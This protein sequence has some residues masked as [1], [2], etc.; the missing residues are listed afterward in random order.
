[1]RI[2]AVLDCRADERADSNR[3]GEMAVEIEAAGYDS[4]WVMD[5]VVMPRELRTSYPAT[6]D[7]SLPPGFLDR[8]WYEAVVSLCIA[9]MA[10][11]RVELGTAVLVLPQREPLLFA[12]QIASV[13]ATLRRRMS[14]GIGAGWLAEEFHVLG[15]NFASRGKRFDEAI[16]LLMSA[17]N[18]VVR[19]YAGE[20]FSVPHEVRCS[21]TPADLPELLIGGWSHASLLRAARFGVGW[22][23]LQ[24]VEEIDCGAIR[25]GVE[26]IS[27]MRSADARTVR[28]RVALRLGGV[29]RAPGKAAR[30]ITQLAVAGV[31]DLIIDVPQNGPLDM[32][33]VRAML[34][35]ESSATT[36]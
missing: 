23:P 35:A 13:Q 2:G 1:M 6:P 26:R 11:S 5:H 10:T 22:L 17:W 21:P 28:P 25:K 9:G 30:S 31:T 3:L 29:A 12:K 34:L 14:L 19:P 27:A 7:G 8:P 36:G 4:L 15:A 32:C 33:D 18:G 24:T 20:H 16:E